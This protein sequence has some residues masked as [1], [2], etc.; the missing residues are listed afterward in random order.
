VDKKNC[1]GPG[2]SYDMTT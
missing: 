1:C 2:G